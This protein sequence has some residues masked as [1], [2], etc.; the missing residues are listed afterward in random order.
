MPYYV[1]VVELDKDVITSRKFRKA[2]PSM[3]PNLP[4]F[5][6]GQSY[7]LPKIRFQ[8]HKNGYKA[9]RFVKKYGLRLCH[10][11]FKKFNPIKTREDA[12]AIERYIAYTLRSKGHGAW[13][14]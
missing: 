1:Y 12:E 9:N 10:N 4:C 6:V 5:Y 7:H 2:N 11:L 3:N 8:Q 13:S 14:N